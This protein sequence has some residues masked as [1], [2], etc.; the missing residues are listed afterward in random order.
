MPGF[1]KVILIILC[2]SLT[3]NLLLSQPALAQ[4]S[5]SG[6]EFSG[7]LYMWAPAIK[8]ESA[9]GGDIDISFNDIV[10]NLDFTFMGMLTARKEKFSLLVDVVYMDL[11][12]DSDYTLVR[13]PL[14]QVSLSLNEIEMQSWVVTPAVAY[15]V[16]DTDRLLLDLVA[17][18][19]YLY[20]KTELKL[21]ERGPL[22]TRK[23]SPS[24]SNHVWDGIVGIRGDVRLNAKWSLPFHFD[25][26]AGET[27]LT[28]Q[29]FVGAAYRFNKME[30][31]AGY[32]HLEWDFD[33]S[34]TGGNIFN[35]L[36][37]SGPILGVRYNF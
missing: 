14:N 24:G 13:G 8:G 16:M 15:T 9:L 23:F 28:W 35:D 22:V 1:C 21:E 32:R 31:V 11:E 17:G 34:D 37:I 7:G 18:A 33:D 25:V 19:R 26:G 29:A 27:D 36:Y 6:W 3:I 2:S 12:D 20:L 5:A 30:L 4:E 10:D